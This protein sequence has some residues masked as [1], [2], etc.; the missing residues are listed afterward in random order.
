VL[1]APIRRLGAAYV[2]IGRRHNEDSWTSSQAAF[3]MPPSLPPLDSLRVLAACVRHGN[4][5]RAADELC[6]TPS[7][8]SLRMR[9]LE[10]QLGVRLFVRHGP[11]LAV[12]RE[13][14]LLAGT[15]E[16]ALSSIRA[17]I[18][19]CRET[20]PSLR[21][22]CAPAFAARWLVPR[23]TAYHALPDAQPVA[24]DV[25]DV[26]LAPNA[27]DIAIRSGTGPW[28]GF[29]AV[30]LLAELGTPML[31]PSLAGD[32]P[33]TPA[34]LLDLPLIPDGRWASWF[35]LAGMPDAKPTFAAT[36]FA[37]YE[38]EAAAAMKGAGV[39]LL[40]PFLYAELVADGALLAPF[41]T[42]VTGPARYWALWRGGS[43]RPRFVCWIEDALAVR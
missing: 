37:S 9:R 7:A 18:E 12:T 32:A 10:S 34:R 6:L 31:S 14:V 27:F 15:V 35:K 28:P 4:F 2:D 30:E 3:E 13:G 26:V 17:A 40:S 29:Q 39:A 20:T 1:V 43:E 36:R 25:T 16:E 38:L 21:V 5:S 23:L 42:A 24:L 11:Q 19:R 41:D 22:T 8:V 33:M